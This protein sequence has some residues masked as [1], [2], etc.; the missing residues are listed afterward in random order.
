MPCGKVIVFFTQKKLYTHCRQTLHYCTG[1]F[2]NLQKSVTTS[3]DFEAILFNQV[4][5]CGTHV[6]ELLK[7]LLGLLWRLKE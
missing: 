6:Q 7:F 5:I 3:K 4:F 1:K 2:R